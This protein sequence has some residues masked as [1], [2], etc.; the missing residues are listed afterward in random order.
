VLYEVHRLAYQQ[1]SRLFRDA[2]K[3]ITLEDKKWGFSFENIC[4]MLDVD[5]EYLRRGLRDWKIRKLEATERG[6]SRGT[7]ASAQTDIAEFVIGNDVPGGATSLCG[8]E[9]ALRDK[10]KDKRER[11]VAE[12]R[13]YFGDICPHSRRVGRW[14]S[15][16]QRSPSD[17]S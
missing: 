17:G 13:R 16:P 14:R 3:W 10:I 4:E 8:T 11:L 2:E 6:L 15:S 1:G 7:P 5:P 9:Q 12:L